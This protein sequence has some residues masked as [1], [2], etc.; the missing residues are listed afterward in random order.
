M[1]RAAVKT[2]PITVKLTPE[3]H[4]AVMQRAERCGLRLAAWVRAILIQAATKPAS[5]GHLRIKEPDGALS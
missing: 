2:K 3:Q 4:R 1:A 5:D